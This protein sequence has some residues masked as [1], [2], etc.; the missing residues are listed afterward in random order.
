MENDRLIESYFE[1]GELKL[2]EIVNEYSSYVFTII[3]NISKSFLKNDD[4]EELISDVFFAV[5]KNQNILDYKYPIKPYIAGIARNLTKN[6]LRSLSIYV[7]K[8]IEETEESYDEEIEEIL[9]SKEKIEIIEEAL[10]E[11]EEDAKVF[12][13]F[14]YQGK[15]SKEIAQILNKTEFNINTKLHRMRK[16]I[17]IKLEERGYYYGK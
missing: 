10:K 7:F 2:K 6:K 3:Q 11:F 16:K 8:P 5:W 13:M 9:E 15:K 4:I 14:Y 17:K 1:N 12:M